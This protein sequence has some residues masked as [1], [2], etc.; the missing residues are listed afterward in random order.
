MS[1]ALLTNQKLLEVLGLQGL[2]IASLD[3]ACRVNELPRVTAVTHPRESMQTV[4]VQHFSLI[5]LDAPASTQA[6]AKA[7]TEEKPLFDLDAM[8]LAATQRIH[9][10]INRI[11]RDHLFEI[12]R[13]FRHLAD[14]ARIRSVDQEQLAHIVKTLGSVYDLQR[15]GR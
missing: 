14:P 5:A 4:Q 3:I 7:V 1:K 8:C 2:S 13:E 6:P 9:S 10:H 11:A 12:K 15:K